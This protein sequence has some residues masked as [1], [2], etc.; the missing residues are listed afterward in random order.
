MLAKTLQQHSRRLNSTTMRAF[1]AV[2]KPSGDHLFLTADANK[3][4][5]VFDGLQASKP[6]T[7]VL[8]NVYRHHND[9]PLIK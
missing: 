4:T 7:V 2:Q 3:K 9:L 5:R 6:H 8:D 1:G